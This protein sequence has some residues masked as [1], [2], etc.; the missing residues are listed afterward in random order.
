M[1]NILTNTVQSAVEQGYFQ[2][3]ESAIWDYVSK[4]NPN[5]FNW[6][7]ENKYELKVDVVDDYAIVMV[8]DKGKPIFEDTFCEAGFPDKD[9]RNNPN[10]NLC[11]I[12]M[13]AEEVQ[14]VCQ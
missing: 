2:K 14:S 12:T 5:I 1:L 4:K 11:K 6:F 3:G 9:H 7:K 8:C 10:L 13:T